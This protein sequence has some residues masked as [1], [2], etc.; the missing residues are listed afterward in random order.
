MNLTK[1][2]LIEKTAKK[3][4]RS[5]KEVGLILEAFIE[6]ITLSLAKHEEVSWVGFGQ[7]KVKKRSARMGRN[8]KT[9]ESVQIQALT[10]PTFQPSAALK[11]AIRKSDA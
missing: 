5:Q 4:W 11:A 6:E 8:P 1:K 9:G 2:D 7:F 10:T 3:V